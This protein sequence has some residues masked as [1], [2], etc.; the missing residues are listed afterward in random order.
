MDEE[1]FSKSVQSTQQMSGADKSDLRNS[2]DACEIAKQST[3]DEKP[4]ESKISDVENR[5]KG[6][7]NGVSSENP[8]AGKH[9]EENQQSVLIPDD[10]RNLY[11]QG[12]RVKYS[13][14]DE[15]PGESGRSV[16]NPDVDNNQSDRNQETSACKT[17]ESGEIKTREVSEKHRPD[18]GSTDR[19]EHD[20]DHQ[21]R[22]T[23]KKTPALKPEE[24]KNAT[25]E[26]ELTTAQIEEK[27]VMF[28]LPTSDEQLEQ[29]K[30][31]Y[32]QTDNGKNAAHSYSTDDGHH[33]AIGPSESKPG[34]KTNEV[35]GGNKIL[36]CYKCPMDEHQTKRTDERD[37]TPEQENPQ[38][39][40]SEMAEVESESDMEM[41]EGISIGDD[42]DK[43]ET[44]PS[45]DVKN[46][47]SADRFGEK[48][49]DESN[50][51]SA[52]DKTFEKK[53]TP[54]LNRSETTD[55]Y[56]PSDTPRHPADDEQPDE[57]KMS[58]VKK[59]EED[60]ENGVASEN[61]TDGGKRCEENEES[62]LELDDKRDTADDGRN[63][64]SDKTED[65]RNNCMPGHSDDRQE[66]EGELSAAHPKRETRSLDDGGINVTE[67]SEIVQ[68]GGKDEVKYS[69][70]DNQ[71]EEMMTS[72]RD[73]FLDKRDPNGEKNATSECS[74]EYE[75]REKGEKPVS[76]SDDA[77]TVNVGGKEISDH[78][79]EKD[80]TVDIAEYIASNNGHHK[81][82]ETAAG[83]RGQ[84]NS[85]VTDYSTVDDENV[86]GEG[87]VVSAHDPDQTVQ[88]DGRDDVSGHCVGDK[89]HQESEPNADGTG[90][91]ASQ[92]ASENQSVESGAGDKGHSGNIIKIRHYNYASKL[93]RRKDSEDSKLNEQYGG[94]ST[95]K[96]KK[97]QKKGNFDIGRSQIQPAIHDLQND[98]SI[99][100][101]SSRGL[102][103]PAKNNQNPAQAECVDLS[104]KRPPSEPQEKMPTGQNGARNKRWSTKVNQTQPT[105]QNA[106]QMKLSEGPEQHY[107]QTSEP[108]NAISIKQTMVNNRSNQEVKQQEV[109]IWIN[110][111]QA[112]QTEMSK[113]PAHFTDKR[114]VED[115][116]IINNKMVPSVSG[117][118]SP[119]SVS[120]Q[121]YTTGRHTF[122]NVS[123]TPDRH[124]ARATKPDYS[125]RKKPTYNDR[126][127]STK[128]PSDVGRNPNLQGDYRGFAGKNDV[129]SNFYFCDLY[130][131]NMYFWSTEQAYQWRKAT[132]MGN[133][134]AAKEIYDA[135]YASLATHIANKYFRG[136]DLSKWIPHRVP[137][138]RQLIRAK[139]RSCK[140]FREELR[141]SGDRYIAEVVP[142][143]Q[144]WAIGD[145]KGRT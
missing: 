133:K 68:M 45:S 95:R 108:G 33:D 111:K 15:Q 138:M 81:E 110:T 73:N 119:S 24:E 88:T 1:K 37:D 98:S 97:M 20:S 6:E 87:K 136:A 130:V 102:N 36:A 141:D 22:Q 137:V 52:N 101:P 8:T 103:N 27:N 94:R 40:E 99:Q 142:G 85:S 25:A 80:R 90:P 2:S 109:N 117:A 34:E 39:T 53:A 44:E 128:S 114:Q 10:K 60:G 145:G 64:T 12:E 71:L 86:I 118:T 61:S 120:R 4:G 54:V 56:E 51:Q 76:G 49:T 43:T 62:V 122:N 66:K 50:P 144:Y 57:S 78:A 7:E 116:G 26:V 96:V 35:G 143:D 58:V 132:F 92:T 72:D 125:K 140:L 38:Q 31:P 41:E 107:R 126:S 75:Q 70:D 84:E 13:S 74:T 139:A 63:E 55:K 17:Q 106:T 129:L 3:N 91:D 29:S 113:K 77:K 30:I 46:K 67:T 79:N 9:C 28:D 124:Q 5:Q 11:D 16:P 32:R 48:V 131:Y 93:I 19:M 135:E 89:Q 127:P 21:L 82:S 42:Q 14:K 69:T 65:T 121:D 23:S 104:N 100:Q 47:S 112:D 59:R 83:G 134:Q 123:P 115:A 18:E 105:A